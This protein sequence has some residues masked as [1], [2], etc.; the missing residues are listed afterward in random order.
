INRTA[1]DVYRAWHDLENLPRFMSHLRSVRKDG[2]RSRWVAKAPAGMS[3]EWDAQIV[4]DKPG[5]LIAWRSLE[6]SEVRT[7]GS[8]HFNPTRDG[9]GTEVLVELKYDPPGGKLGTWLA[10]LF[11]EEPGRQVREDLQRFKEMMESGQGAARAT[12]SV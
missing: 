3:A 2:N 7:A 9:R 4:N 11:G 12:A 8:V 5:R 6:G 1:E 10:W